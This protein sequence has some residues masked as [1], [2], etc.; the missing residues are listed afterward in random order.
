M[1]KKKAGK[2]SKT[3]KSTP[4][5][6]ASEDAYVPKAEASFEAKLIKDDKLSHI[7]PVSTMYENWF[8]Q[9]A[10]YVILE[11]AVPYVEDGLKPVQRRIMH[12]LKELDDG[13]FNKVANVIG[14]TMKYHP[15]GDASIGDA[16]VQLGQK[17]LLIE[18]QGNWGNIFTGDSAAAPR[19]IEARLSKFALDVAFNP[20]TTTWQLSYDGRNKE[21][22]ALPMKFPL[23]LAQGVEGIAV[24]LACKI[25][26]HNFCELIEA[27]IDALRKKPI[28]ILPDFPTGG[29]ADFSMYM[30]GMR[31]GKVRVRAKIEKRDKK[32]LVITQIPFGTTTTS[33][34]ESII[35]ANEKGKI[36]IK[37]IEDNTSD[38]VEIVVHLHSDSSE[39][40]DKTI[41]AL[42]A[43]TDCEV[44]VSPNAC[45]IQDDKPR[46]VDVNEILRIS[47]FNTVDLLKKERE[48]KLAE[49]M[50]DWHFSSL[51]K[52]F[53]EKKIYR[54]IE[55]A[56]TW[57]AVLDN[58][59]KGLKPYRKKFRREITQE[60]IAQ[61]TEIKIK[62]ISKFD[63]K[64][65]DEH[66]KGL[67]DQM[68]NV[69]H[70]LDNITSYA[71]NYFKELLKKYGKGRER[72]TEISSF[73]N[74]V[75][76]EVVVANEKLYVN[77]VEGFAGIGL[78]KD[79]FVCECSDI[80]DIIAFRAD[81]NF[82]VSK[83]ADKK[84]FGKDIIHIALYNKSNENTVYNMIYRDGLKG[85]VMVKRF[86]VGGVTRDKE[87]C[88]TRGTERSKVMYFAISNDQN[89]EQVVIH[90]L[91][92]PKLRKLTIEFSFKE[93]AVKGRSSM[94]NIIS[95]NTV[96]R[97]VRFRPAG[98]GV[99]AT[100]QDEPNMLLAT[101]LE[102]E[103]AKPATPIS[104]IILPDLPPPVLDK[105]EPKEKPVKKKKKTGDDGEN[106]GE[107]PQMSLF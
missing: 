6:V 50:E 51:E 105:K 32:S 44:G 42:F 92:K 93:L 11:R 87:Y 70:D 18:T 3:K 26:P 54:D 15:H 41:N 19:Y 30:G 100:E 59:D 96:S 107:T 49:L 58:I 62:R 78:K 17:N 99:S 84:Y 38:K 53:I 33:L 97:V 52:I 48:I 61:L 8:L 16:M 47:A 79:E 22:L 67:D 81:G 65:A 90:L 57:E 2:V 24:G 56:E 66:I 95:R 4:T 14:N 55:D 82:M 27:S 69:Q 23:L 98:T 10:S 12:S 71:I 7:L 85:N 20:Q 45:I 25:M 76:R 28:N 5:K 103:T 31:G 74:I 75:A 13:R 21:P 72:K 39:D 106:G 35:T 64:K 60:D 80:D 36:K 91:P 77:R 1:A 40:L 37:K 73:G 102:A 9:Y 43:F 94:G 46:F 34:I 68:K 83:V 89:L 29:T 86:S 88:L 63:A 104:E 101:D